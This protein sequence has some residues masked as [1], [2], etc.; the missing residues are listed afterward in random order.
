[1]TSLVTRCE[2][3]YLNLN[4]SQAKKAILIEMVPSYKFV[5]VHIDKDL[6]W[7]EN[8]NAPISVTR[9]AQVLW[10]Q[11]ESSSF[12]QQSILASVLSMLW[13]IGETK[14]SADRTPI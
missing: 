2:D 3:N 8:T 5:G 14:E 11:S 4:I 13:V 1:M 6:S 10:G 12:F 9:G 7:K